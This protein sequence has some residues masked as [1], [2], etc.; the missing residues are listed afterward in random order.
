MSLRSITPTLPKELQFDEEL[1]A[2]VVWVESEDA[3]RQ[4]IQMTW[5]LINVE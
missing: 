5:T 1:A 4:L 3:C 2:C